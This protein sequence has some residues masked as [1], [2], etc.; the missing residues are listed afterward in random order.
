MVMDV[1]Q[2]YCGDPFTIYTNIELLWCTPETNI[3]Y[4]TYASIKNIKIN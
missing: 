2:I 4:V 3:M 1:N